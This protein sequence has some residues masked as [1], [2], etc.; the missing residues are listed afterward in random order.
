MTLDCLQ[1]VEKGDLGARIVPDTETEEIINLQFGINSMINTIK[2]RTDELL[3]TTEEKTEIASKLLKE[4]IQHK[5]AEI[6]FL[7]SQINPHFLYN[8]LECMNSIGALHEVTE[9]QEIAMS[10]LQPVPLCP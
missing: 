2:L 8:T 6:N 7:Q 10:P 5:E 9:I 4:E 1:K 3:R